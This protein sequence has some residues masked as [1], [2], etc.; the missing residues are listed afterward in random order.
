MTDVVPRLGQGDVPGLLA[1][2]ERDLALEGEQFG[3]L[4]SDDLI[5]GRG[6]RAG[7]LQEVAGCLGPAATL[8]GTRFKCHMYGDDFPRLE[9]EGL[10]VTHVISWLPLA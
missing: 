3:A 1:D 4:R 10:G 8:R 9:G 7:R 5:T 2:D 6:E